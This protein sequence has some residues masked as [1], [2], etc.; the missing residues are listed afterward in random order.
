MNRV[1]SSEIEPAPAS[2]GEGRC[3]PGICRRLHSFFVLYDQYWLA[4]IV[5]VIW[6]FVFQEYFLFNRIF[7]F[8]KYAADTITQFYPIEYFRVNNFLSFHIPFWSFQFGL[9]ESVYNFIS[10]T[11]PF[12]IIYLFFGKSGFTEATAFI[13][14]IK[15][16][17]AALFFHAF[18]KKIGVS[19]Y[20]S[21]VGSIIYTFSGYM[22]LNSH[23]YH[24]PNYAVY[25]AMF[26]YFFE[27]WYQDKVWIPIVIIIGLLPIKGLLQSLHIAFFGFFYIFYRCANDIGINRKL[28]KVYIRI[29]CLYLLGII[30]W[31]YFFI[32]EIYRFVASARVKDA[33]TDISYISFFEKIFQLSEIKELIIII[34]R[35]FSPDLL[36]SWI[37]YHGIRNY[38]EDSSMYIGV[39]SFALFFVPFFWR[40]KRHK[41]LWIFPFITIIFIVFP[42]LRAT[43]NAFVSGSFKYLS[44]Y[45]GF[46]ALFSSLIVLQLLLNKDTEYRVVNNIKKICFFLFSIYTVLFS[47]ILI[48]KNIADI[49]FNLHSLKISFIFISIFYLFIFFYKKEYNGYVVFLMCLVLMAEIIFSSRV[50]AESIP[51]KFFPFFKERNEYYFDKNIMSALHYIKESD[52]N[53]YRI[54]KDDPY[55]GLND[56]LIQDYFGTKAYLGFPAKG[57]V[58]FFNNYGLIK[59]YG[60]YRHGLEAKRHL[61]NLLLV[62]YLLCKNPKGCDHLDGFSLLHTV[63]D[64]KI[65][66]NKQVDSFGKIFYH[67]ITSADFLQ[68]APAE[69]TSLIPDVVVSAETLPGI[70]GPTE[71]SAS[72]SPKKDVFR[73]DAWHEEFFSG[74]IDLQ[75]PGILFFPVPFDPGWRVFVNG[76]PA[77]LLQLDFAFSGV[78][79]TKPGPYHVVLRYRPPFVIFGI[80]MSCAGILLTLYLWRR[81][82]RFPAY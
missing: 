21:F 11:S 26:L 24:Y 60:P 50:V 17:A 38:F 56:A 72:A 5:L 74:S 33:V 30:V 68:L 3:L 27:L 73:L 67:Q 34:S 79:L 82:P 59:S 70:P 55:A 14:L 62:K 47:L 32:P 42:Y 31:S 65:Y 2:A 54:E 8:D 64:V 1:N 13:I 78:A 37:Y 12:D 53:F 80:A 75:R 69:K 28:L 57:I 25:A 9:G 29:S 41:F 15:F 63:G 4:L 46:Y 44:F 76:K 51:G 77:H 16:L 22:I 7:L 61:Q 19:P 39:A 6:C 18:L 52:N 58:E 35:F 66:Q 81:W 43:L 20:L 10:G 71:N 48:Y 36:Y 40:E 49:H 23:W 45:L